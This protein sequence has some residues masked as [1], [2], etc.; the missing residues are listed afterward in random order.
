MPL[1]AADQFQLEAAVLPN[2][3]AIESIVS[4]LLASVQDIRHFPKECRE[5]A[6]T[7][8]A[9]STKYNELQVGLQSVNTA[10]DFIQCIQD[11]NAFVDQC[12]DWPTLYIG[13]EAVVRA[14]FQDL[15]AR[16]DRIQKSFDTEI[17]VNISPP[18]PSSS[19]M[20]IHGSTSSLRSIDTRLNALSLS[21]E[22]AKGHRQSFLDTIATLKQEMKL[23]HQQSLRQNS[24]LLPLDFIE[25]PHPDVV[26]TRFNNDG[27]PSYGKY[28]DVLVCFERIHRPPA[29]NLGRIVRVY[30][31]IGDV[32]LV[33]R[34]LAIAEYQDVKYALM[35][36][37]SRDKTLAEK[38]TS[39]PWSNVTQ[40]EKLN[41]AYELAATVSALHA[42]HVVIKVLSDKNVYIQETEG[43]L[44]PKLTNLRKARAI[45]EVTSR[46]EQDPQFKAPE[47]KLAGP[48][49]PSTHSIK[50][51]IWA[52]GV[53]L[54]E[55]FYGIPP[56]S[57]AQIPKLIAE[58]INSRSSSTEDYDRSVPDAFL[59]IIKDCFEPH[60]L[61][62][63]K[64]ASQIAQYL[65]ELFLSVNSNNASVGLP[66][67]LGS[68][69]E[70]KELAAE[71]RGKALAG[72]ARAE[73]RKRMNTRPEAQ[74]TQENRK[75]LP[76]LA[77]QHLVEE[78][79]RTSDP[80]LCYAVGMG[81][82]WYIFEPEEK[83]AGENP[84]SL[85]CRLARKS[86]PFLETAHQRGSSGVAKSLALAHTMLAKH[87]EDLQKAERAEEELS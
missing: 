49:S 2:L 19:E 16:L 15:K 14:R 23:L 27:K 42:A 6:N 80:E 10:P 79:D 47:T 54:A 17:L 7:C 3:S 70:L 30:R 29:D 13:W 66:S 11:V 21:V 76:Y 46:E 77:V 33:Q 25:L 82:L 78:A 61:Y 84:M 58:H 1:S 45:W 68:S 74:S 9:L 44:R 75:K 56:G 60:P 38:V 50:S 69:E 34:L 53:L 12:K 24:P 28:C 4:K 22:E 40:V 81:Y 31:L 35:E 86:I 72:E 5:L 55:L 64:T 8:I 20:A 71:I 63:T 26:I 62:R 59:A 67:L 32:A 37:M 39:N 65:F 85:R 87:Y 36:D 48:G 41:L 52:L 43:H 57:S 18:S 73:E 51:D 83:L